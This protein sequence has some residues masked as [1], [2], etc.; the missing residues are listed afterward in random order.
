V[1]KEM[2]KNCGATWSIAPKLGMNCT[3]EINRTKIQ[4]INVD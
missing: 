4:F 1:I 3:D 2:K